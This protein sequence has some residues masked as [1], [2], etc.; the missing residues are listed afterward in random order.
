MHLFNMMM[1]EK[2]KKWLQAEYSTSKWPF[3]VDIPS[4]TSASA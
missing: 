2:T 1:A 3:L 4:S